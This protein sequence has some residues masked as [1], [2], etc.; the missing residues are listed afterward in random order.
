MFATILTKTPEICF[1]AIFGRSNISVQVMNSQRSIWE[2]EAFS[3]EFDV[4][5]VGGGIVGMNTAIELAEASPE[6][7]I[8]V[9]DRWY[10]PLGAST[11]NA[12][13]ATFGSLSEL[14]ADINDRG[15]DTCIELIEK[16]WKGLA[17]LRNRVGDQS[18]DY[19]E[20]EGFELFG[21]NDDHRFDTSIKI[22]D[23]M[24][25][26]LADMIGHDQ[27]FTLVS[28]R[29][30]QQ[31]GVEAKHM[32]RCS[33][34][35]YLHPGKMMA[36][37]RQMAMDKGV[38][39]YMPFEVQ[40]WQRTAGG[41]QLSSSMGK[42]LITKRL[43]FATNGFIGRFFP[44]LNVQPARNQVILT[45]PIDDLK[46]KGCYHYDE[47]YIYFRDYQNRV[48]LGGARNIDIDGETTSELGLTDRIQ[49]HL[50]DFLASVVLPGRKFKIEYAWSGIM[51]VGKEK[52]PM[53]KEVDNHIFV[54]VR[55]GG[56]GVA[57]GT[58]IGQQLAGQVLD[59]LA[60]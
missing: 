52:R 53:I 24:N 54:A 51:G 14:A 50:T 46:I 21:Q 36:T 38:L 40:E 58:S 2:D 48:L 33:A 10:E 6:L 8:G 55:L 22:L 9:V 13:F 25:E 57:I 30:I 34:E 29:D 37:L 20:N 19:E 27:I 1:C 15:W 43:A 35:G 41:I 59:S 17:A 23:Q 39:M 5:V 31:S 49:K 28:K 3:N 26:V 45:E 47:G 32:I 60:T 44:E 42:K 56:M 12:G 11:R 18:I 16:R 7:R 4:I